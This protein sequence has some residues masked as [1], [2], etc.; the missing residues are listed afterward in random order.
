MQKRVW[1]T[2]AGFPYKRKPSPRYAP[3]EG[4]TDPP[5]LVGEGLKGREWPRAIPSKQK[6]RF[7][8][9]NQRKEHWTGQPTKKRARSCKGRLSCRPGAWMRH[10]RWETVAGLPYKKSIICRELACLACPV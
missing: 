1:E 7:R 5:P 2:V 9:R 6:A 8:F 10:K 3:K 4:A